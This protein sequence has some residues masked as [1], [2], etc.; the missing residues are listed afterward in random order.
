MGERATRISPPTFSVCFWLASTHTEGRGV[1]KKSRKGTFFI[2][3]AAHCELYKP[4]PSQPKPNKP[5]IASAL[6]KARSELELGPIQFKYKHIWHMVT[7]EVPRWNIVFDE[8]SGVTFFDF[9]LC[10]F[11]SPL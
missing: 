10:L 6:E 4:P 11:I 1:G 3:V 7:E 5:P 2:L 9:Y 8:K